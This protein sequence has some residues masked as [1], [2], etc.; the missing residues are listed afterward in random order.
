MKAKLQYK[1]FLVI[2]IRT[3]NGERGIALYSGDKDGKP[4]FTMDFSKAKVFD[5]RKE[6]KKV[7]FKGY[8]SIEIVKI[9]VGE[10]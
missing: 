2:R 3:N 9:P 7:G 8:K 4:L 1:Y 6:A 5:S 10:E